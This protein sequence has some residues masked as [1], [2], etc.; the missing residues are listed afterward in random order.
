MERSWKDFF[1]MN[2]R[3][4]KNRKLCINASGFYWY[5][6]SHQVISLNTILCENFT[7]SN[8][9]SRVSLC[10]AKSQKSPFETK[11]AKASY[12][13]LHVFVLPRGKLNSAKPRLSVAVDE[14]SPRLNHRL[15]LRFDRCNNFERYPLYCVGG[16]FRR[17][18]FKSEY[19]GPLVQSLDWAKHQKGTALQGSYPEVPQAHTFLDRRFRNTYKV[20]GKSSLRQRNRFQEIPMTFRGRNRIGSRNVQS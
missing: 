13:P 10:Y 17:P 8:A 2:K 15:N 11:L 7:R 6:L 20:T 4:F 14:V 18:S 19:T 5:Q 16:I 12:N 1:L 3:L 9:N